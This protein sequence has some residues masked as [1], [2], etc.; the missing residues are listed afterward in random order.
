MCCGHVHP[1]SVSPDPTAPTFIFVFG[2]RVRQPQL[3]C[4]LDSN[5]H[6]LLRGSVFHNP[7]AHLGP[8]PSPLLWCLLVP[9]WRVASSRPEHSAAACCG[10]QDLLK[11]TPYRKNSIGKDRFPLEVEWFT[12]NVTCLVLMGC[13]PC[14]VILRNYAKGRQKW[15]SFWS[16]QGWW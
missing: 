4:V 5:D 3:L 9:P 8:F 1:T 14:F 13:L 6:I 12:W 10:H 2:V 16:K 7:P 15:N 11:V